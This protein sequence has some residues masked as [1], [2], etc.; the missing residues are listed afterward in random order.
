MR[1]P[2]RLLHAIAGFVSLVIILRFLGNTA[3]AE[4]Y[5]DPAA[6]LA[7]KSWIVWRL[8]VLIVALAIAGATGF[9][10]AG[11][12][13]RGLA[14]RKLARMRVIAANGILVLVPAA[15]FLF[16][17]ADAGEFDATFAALQ[18]IEFIAGSVNIVLIGLSFRDGLRLTGRLR[19]S[20]DASARRS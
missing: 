5:G 13:P 9:A 2:L 6:I 19:R 20:S 11:P 12:S 17:K 15:I 4:L 14:A 1:T 8:P 10:L 7:V 18:T 3:Y 16:W